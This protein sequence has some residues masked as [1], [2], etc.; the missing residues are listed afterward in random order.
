VTVES[1]RLNRGVRLD[2]DPMAAAPS[3]R[4]FRAHEWRTYRDLRLRALTD[5][6]DAFEATLAGEE[7]RADGE[8]ANRLALGADDRWNLPLLAEVA[9]Q[10]VG[11]AWGRIEKTT[12]D[13]ARVY[14]MWVAPAHRG[15]G[16]G[17]ILLE[18]II[19]WASAAGVRRLGLGVTCGESPARGLYVRAGF[20]PIGQAGP[21]RPGSALLVQPMQK[22]LSSD[23]VRTRS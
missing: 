3:V 1:P 17:R 10:P 20:T 16:A 7:S 5:S 2:Q 22:L 21:L 14:Q 19:A 8:W 18:A 11:L 15:Q 9:A 23:A 4:P 6:P 13:V 12:P